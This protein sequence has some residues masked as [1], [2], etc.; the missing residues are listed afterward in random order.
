M[1]PDSWWI[2]SLDTRENR[3]NYNKL[4]ECYRPPRSDWECALCL[5]KL[6]HRSYP[7]NIPFFDLLIHHLQALLDKIPS[8][9]NLRRVRVTV[10]SLRVYVTL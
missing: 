3:F 6:V 5:L 2:Q 1:D 8:V 7:R 10:R 4:A 9:T